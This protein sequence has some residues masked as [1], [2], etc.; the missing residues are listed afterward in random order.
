MRANDDFYRMVDMLVENDKPIS[1]GEMEAFRK[2]LAERVARSSW[3]ARY[4]LV[5][6]VIGF[7]LAIIGYLLLDASLPHWLGRIGLVLGAVGMCLT[8]LGAFWLLV[9]HVPM[10]FIA[11]RNFR[12]SMLTLLI[13]KVDEISRRL[14]A[15][16]QGK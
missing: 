16:T 4:A 2:K 11:R 1:E 8:P 13:R 12:D 5:A 6:L 10:Y 14:D 15:L 9:Y 7:P 3:R